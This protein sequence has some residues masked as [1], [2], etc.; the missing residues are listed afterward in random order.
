M[1][2]ATDASPLARSAAEHYARVLRPVYGGRKWI[3]FGGPVAGLLRTAR[4]LRALGAEG[5]FLLGDGMGTGEAPGPADGP[6]AALPSG[7]G[8]IIEA[9][10]RGEAELGRLPPDVLAALDAWDPGGAARAYGWFT[11][12][13]VE[14][15]GGRR[16]FAA[17]P[18]RWAALED[19]VAVE[20]FWDAAGVRRAPSEIVPADGAS[21]RAAA[22]RLDRGLGTAWAG[23]AREG[24]HGGA[25][26]LR[27]IRAEEAAAGAVAFF[28]TR[29]DRVRVM[30]FLEG[31][32]CSIHG[33]V[34]PGGGTSV[35]RPVE[36]VVLRRPGEGRLLYAG[37]ATYWDPP[38]TDR[39]AMRA[40]GRRVAEALRDRV[41]FLGGFTVDGVLSEE[42]FLPT[43]LNA[44]LGAGHNMLAASIPDLP[45]TPL[46]LAAAEGLPLDWRPDLLEAALLEAADARRQGG[47]WSVFPGTRTSTEKHSLVEEGGSF[48]PAREGEAAAASAEVGPGPA[49][50]FLR[51]LPAAGALPRGPSVAPWAVRVLAAADAHLGTAIGPLEP[52][53]GAR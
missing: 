45:F 35:F 48:R 13:G 34:F 43:E 21:L 8:D 31:I 51:I 16:R 24:L 27:W 37:A 9:M 7:G 1:T 30:P 49:G 47:A 44:R 25:V 28:A 22:R 52:A 11:L 15:V 12:T 20:A 42:G 18:P 50:P 10:R 14:E 19:K 46:A 33:V 29:C 36:M 40:V 23:D 2:D 41:G 32:P 38:A 6:W 3:V 17:R 5:T 39:E 4:G 26:C 53:R